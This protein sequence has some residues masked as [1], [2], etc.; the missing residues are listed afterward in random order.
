VIITQRQ[1]DVLHH[2]VKDAQAWADHAE[3]TA[4]PEKAKANVEAKVAKW[5]GEYD[6][7]VAAGNYKSRNVKEAEADQAEQDRY[8]NASYDKKRKRT[9]KTTKEQLDMIYWDKINGTDN[10]ANHVSEIKEKYPKETS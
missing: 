10:W 2:V 4:G 6:A 7:E 5:A 9:Y 8:D 1:K 3:A